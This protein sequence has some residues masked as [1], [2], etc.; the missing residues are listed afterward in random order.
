MKFLLIFLSLLCPKTLLA[1]NDFARYKIDGKI[2]FNS[3]VKKINNI[4]NKVECVYG[5]TSQAE[6]S[7][8]NNFSADEQI[9]FQIKLILYI[10]ELQYDLPSQQISTLLGNRFE[11]CKFDIASS[12]GYFANRKFILSE[13]Y[14]QEYLLGFDQL[15]K[16]KERFDR[17]FKLLN[18]RFTHFSYEE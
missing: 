11:I 8:K 18:K 1:V 17:L 3:D 16:K 14:F 2:F 9:I 6:F 12:N 7:K 15:S 10:N 5:Q 4:L 13:F